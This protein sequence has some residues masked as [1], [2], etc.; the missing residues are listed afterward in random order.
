MTLVEYIWRHEEMNFRYK[1]S[2]ES[3]FLLLSSVIWI[4]PFSQIGPS[5]ISPSPFFSLSW[6]RETMNFENILEED[7]EIKEMDNLQV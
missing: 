1:L 3:K 5:R 4:N 2:F 7:E 6:V